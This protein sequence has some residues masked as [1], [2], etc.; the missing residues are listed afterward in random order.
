VASAGVVDAL[1]A[2][3]TSLEVADTR[4]ALVAAAAALAAADPID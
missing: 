2:H 4:A 3:V 1:P